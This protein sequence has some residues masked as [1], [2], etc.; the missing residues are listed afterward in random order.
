MQDE[1]NKIWGKD[2][3]EILQEIQKKEF[4]SYIEQIKEQQPEVVYAIKQK[5]IAENK[6]EAKLIPW[7]E[8][9]KLKWEKEVSLIVFSDFECSYCVDFHNQGEVQK[10]LETHSWTLEYSFMN[11]PLPKHENGLLQATSAKCVEKLSDTQSYNTYIN[12]L[13]EENKNYTSE[14]L[15]TLAEKLEI[16]PQEFNNCITN[17]ESKQLVE[18]EF[19]QGRK[20]WVEMVPATVIL[21]QYT[22]EYEVLS[23]DIT[24]QEI[25]QIIEEIK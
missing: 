8:M 6:E 20:F 1:Y 11:F 12:T 9:Q 22:G 25:T 2:N 3:Y 21:N 24:S 15:S 10:V 23:G 14:E 18:Q 4:Q 16:N 17:E 13:F 7:N 5:N 19:E